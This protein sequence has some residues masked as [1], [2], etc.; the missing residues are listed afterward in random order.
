V[1]GTGALIWLFGFTGDDAILA[2]LGVAGI[3]CCVA[4]TSG[5]VC[6]DLK[7]GHLV[8]ASPR[9][10][11]VMQILGVFVA[12]FFLCPVMTVL[13]EGSLKAGTGGIG[14]EELA[15]PQAAIFAALVNGFFGDGVL[16]KD[17]IA[18]GAGIGV[19]LLV[20]DK[21]LAAAGS[22]FRLHVM[23]VA[24]GIYLP[25]G[26]AAP[27]LLGGIVRHLVDRRE[28]PGTDTFAQRGVLITSGLIAGES[29]MG[30]LVGFLTFLEFSGWKWGAGLVA[31]FGLSEEAGDTLL[32]WLS[33][34]ALLAVAAWLYRR[35]TKKS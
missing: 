14:G 16:P 30:V 7:T 34:A 3:V 2:T 6:N 20:A 9:N 35:S 23:P 28:A 15:A 11:Q 32:Q 10:Q 17:L 26:L 27:I 8:G 33:L 21:F 22:S 29:L 24:V 18:W 13:H 31:Q 4:C 5:D 19:A 1:L 12:A 25:F